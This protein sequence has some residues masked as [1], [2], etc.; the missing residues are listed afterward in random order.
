MMTTYKVY[1]LPAVGLADAAYLES[2]DQKQL[3]VGPL[4]QHPEVGGQSEV[5]QNH[6]QYPKFKTS[7]DSLARKILS[8]GFRIRSNQVP[9]TCLNI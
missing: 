2:I 7:R 5:I 1:I 8:W 6:I 3:Q 9:A 4:T